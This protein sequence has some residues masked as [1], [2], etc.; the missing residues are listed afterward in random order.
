[1]I[2]KFD[3]GVVLP[4]YVTQLVAAVTTLFSKIIS[5]SEIDRPLERELFSLVETLKE[6]NSIMGQRYQS[7]YNTAKSGL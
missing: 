4:N 2:N 5:N 7:S 3:R 1:M 6:C